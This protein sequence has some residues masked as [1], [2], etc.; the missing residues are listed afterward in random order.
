MLTPEQMERYARQIM[1]PDVG[2]AGQRKLLDARVLVV[3]A[4]GLGSPAAVYLAAAGVGTLGIVDHDELELSNLHRQILHHTPDVGRPKVQSA[5]E[6]IARYNP[7]VR[8]VPHRL[9]FTAANAWRSSPSTISSWV[10]WTISP[11][12]TC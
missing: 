6:T 3:G 11:P 10:R 2:P 8:V 9:R 12:A 5:Q 7:D 4:G 1:I